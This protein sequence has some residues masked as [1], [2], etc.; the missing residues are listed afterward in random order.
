M[1]VL[2]R[3]GHG[4]TDDSRCIAALRV[5]GHGQTSPHQ[6]ETGKTDSAGEVQ[7]DF[8]ASALGVLGSLLPC[9][10]SHP[11]DG[12][13]ELLD[14]ASEEA[15]SF[16]CVIFLKSCGCARI[17]G[18]E[19][20]CVRDGQT[21]LGFRLFLLLEAHR[22]LLATPSRVAHR[23]GA[24]M[25]HVAWIFSFNGSTTTCRRRCQVFLVSV[26]SPVA[27]K[28]VSERCLNRGRA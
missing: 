23:H 16:G 14:A 18:V 3:Y 6:H 10:F 26:T 4:K 5:R 12:P 25:M 22:M 8:D 21:L 2:H 13:Q 1:V 7:E 27:T 28:R 17:L 15:L 24:G 19:Y 9:A 20:L 11:A